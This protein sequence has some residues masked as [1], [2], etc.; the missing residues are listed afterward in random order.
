MELEKKAQQHD[1]TACVELAIAY[2]EGEEC[3][4]DCDKALDYASRLLFEDQEFGLLL[5]RMDDLPPADRQW[6][7]GKLSEEA[8]RIEAVNG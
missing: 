7:E 6:L 8:S 3:T 5:N 1:L 4:R 2:M